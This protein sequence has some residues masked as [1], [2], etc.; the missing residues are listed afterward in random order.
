MQRPTC[1][2]KP[3][4]CGTSHNEQCLIGEL[5]MATIHL[6]AHQ[7]TESGWRRPG[8]RGTSNKQKPQGRL[9][10]VHFRHDVQRQKFGACDG[11]VCDGFCAKLQEM[12]LPW[13]KRGSGAVH[14]DTKWKWQQHGDSERLLP[15]FSDGCNLKIMPFWAKKKLKGGV[16]FEHLSQIGLRVPAVCCSNS[17]APG[18]VLDTQTGSFWVGVLLGSVANSVDPSWPKSWIHVFSGVNEL[19]KEQTQT[20]KAL[21]P[22]HSVFAASLLKINNFQS[23]TFTQPC[24]FLLHRFFEHIFCATLHN[25]VPQL[26]LKLTIQ[27][28]AFLPVLRRCQ[29]FQRKTSRCKR[30]DPPPGIGRPCKKGARCLRTR[31]LPQLAGAGE[32]WGWVSPAAPAL[33][34]R[35]A[36]VFLGQI[37]PPLKLAME[38]LKAR[39]TTL[40][41]QISGRPSHP[42]TLLFCKPQSQAK[43]K[44]VQVLSWPPPLEIWF[45]GS[46]GNFKQLSFLAFF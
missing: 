19:S 43:P 8:N 34:L 41:G 5:I 29:R 22:N 32:S 9:S 23:G 1:R 3:L 13:G 18:S 27:R 4:K 37:A 11:L 21:F 46:L 26:L 24:S 10:F 45:L 17:W 36:L 33:S 12:N 2:V 30:T 31:P 39:V 16:V 44:S 38:C 7:T 40:R 15:C 14:N 6:S 42:L 28:C 20:A 35:K 25:K